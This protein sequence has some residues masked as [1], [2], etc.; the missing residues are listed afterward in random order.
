MS[1]QI[2]EVWPVHSEICTVRRISAAPACPVHAC[3]MACA[4]SLQH[5][6]VLSAW[7]PNGVRTVSAAAACALQGIERA[8]SLRQRP[9][10][11]EGG[12][13]QRAPHLLVRQRGNSHT[14]QLGAQ[15]G[16]ASFELQAP[17]LPC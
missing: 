17:L 15:A 6:P 9:V 3:R 13:E 4:T 11:S 16:T 10:H 2:A 1:D 7:V 5:K 14:C 12:T 8:T